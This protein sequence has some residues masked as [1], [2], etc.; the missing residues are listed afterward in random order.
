MQRLK[1][2]PEISGHAENGQKILFHIAVVHVVVGEIA[3]HEIFAFGGTADAA[4]LF[5]GRHEKPFVVFFLWVVILIG[6][7]GRTFYI[8]GFF[9]HHDRFLVLAEIL[10]ITL[11]LAHPL[12]AVLV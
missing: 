12:P 5:H 4:D 9:E 10:G 7:K 6:Q 2:T 8:R 1:I 11:D 3:A